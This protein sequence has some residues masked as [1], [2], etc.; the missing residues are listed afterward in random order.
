MIVPHWGWGNIVSEDDVYICYVDIV[1][2]VFKVNQKF[3]S[4]LQTSYKIN[5]LKTKQPTSIYRSLICM[6][7]SFGKCNMKFQ[8]P[9]TFLK[10]LYKT[11]TVKSGAIS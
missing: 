3:S 4:N 11:L 6:L 5:Q 8:A 9:L 7:I 1:V 10:I 2:K